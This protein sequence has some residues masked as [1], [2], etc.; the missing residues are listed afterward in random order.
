MNKIIKGTNTAQN[1]TIIST[2]V[3]GPNNIINPNNNIIKNSNNILI[4]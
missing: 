2:D 1:G 4:I 3:A